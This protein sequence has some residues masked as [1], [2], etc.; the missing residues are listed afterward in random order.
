[1]AARIAASGK[2]Y[3]LDRPAEPDDLV[4]EEDVKDAAKL[5]QLLV[6]ILRDIATMKRRFWPRRIDFEDRPVVSG[7]V[8]RLN[9]AF[10]TRV[11]WWVVDWKPATPGDVAVFE[12][13]AGTDADTLCLA[14]ANSGT[15]TM[16]VE[17]AG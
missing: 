14:V 17:S 10:G 2:V 16:R 15:V 9:H 4:T 3:P 7:D 12:R 11:R 5:S 1:M 6:R 13:D 8:M